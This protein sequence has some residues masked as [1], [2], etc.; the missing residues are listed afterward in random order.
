MGADFSSDA[1]QEKAKG[2]LIFWFLQVERPLLPPSGINL[3]LNGYGFLLQ[4]S[5]QNRESL[6]KGL[7]GSR[8]DPYFLDRQRAGF[9]LEL[10]DVFG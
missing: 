3:L 10:P 1:A 7:L 8:V 5:I 2:A 4:G 9:E 6:P